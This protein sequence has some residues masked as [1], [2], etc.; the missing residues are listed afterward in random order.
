MRLAAFRFLLFVEHDPGKVD[1]GFPKRSCS[2]KPWHHRAENRFH[3]RFRH[4]AMV[5]S[6]VSRRVVRHPSGAHRAARTRFISPLPT[7]LG[8]SRVRQY[9]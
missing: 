3:R 8:C 4:D 7:E 5:L 1:T 6:G 9:K 2:I